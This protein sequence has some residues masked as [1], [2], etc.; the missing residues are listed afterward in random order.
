MYKM[1]FEHFPVKYAKL[2]TELCCY[3]DKLVQGAPTSP[4]IS[5]I[6]M[7]DF[8]NRVESFARKTIFLILAIVMILHFQQ[9]FLWTGHITE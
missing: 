6:I 8:D 7:L 4:A 2:F 3:N 5:N 1:F 9:T